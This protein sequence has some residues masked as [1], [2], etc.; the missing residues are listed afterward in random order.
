MTKTLLRAGALSCALLA[1]TALTAPASAQEGPLPRFNQVDANGVDLFTGDFFFSMVEGT[2]GSGDGALSLVRNWAG[3][4]GWTD[5]WSGTLYSTTIGG[6]V[7]VFVQFG[8][9]EDDFTLSGG[10]YTSTKADGASLASAGAGILRYVARD[11]TSIDYAL[12]APSGSSE[13][14][15]CAYTSCGIPLNMRRP[16]GMTYTMNWEIGDVCTQF[17]EGSCNH[18]LGFYRLAGVSSSAN[19]GFTID[20]AS[21][22]VGEDVAP[23]SNWFRRTQVQFTNLD[24]APASLPT[25]T[26]NQVSSTVLDVTDSGGQTWRLTNGSSGRLTGIRRPGAGSDTTAVSYSGASVSAV[27]NEGVATAY[28]RFTSGSGGSMT[29]TDAI[30]GETIAAFSLTTERI[31]SVFDASAHTTGYTYDSS[32]RLTRITQSEGNY[33]QYTYDARGNVTETLVKPKSGSGLPDLV[34]SA[35]YSSTC[36]NPVV[37]NLP[38]SST[39]AR[40][41][42]T[43]YTY[44]STHGGL[45]T[46]TAPAPGGSGDRPQTRYSYSAV[47]AVTG[48]PVTLPTGVS[49]CASGSAAG[50]P[51]CIGTAAESRTVIAYDSDNLRTTSVTQRNGDNSVSATSAFTYDAIGNTLTID[52]PLSGSA[53]TIRFRYDLARRTIGA[54]GPDPD[55]GG[56]LKHR[57]VRTTY[58]NGLPTS[59]EQGNVNSQSDGD[60]AAFAPA[61]RV[62]QIYDA[63][64]RPVAQR[65]ISGSTTYAL[66]QTSY[67]ALGRTRCVAQRMNPATFASP[68]TNACETGTEGSF[69]PDR[70]S[71]IGYD[72]I[73]RVTL[74]E[75]GVGTAAA[76]NERA[77]TY[78]AN[79]QVATV[80]DANGNRTTYVYDGHDR[81]S[82]KRMPDPSTPDTSS[83]SDFEDLT[84]ETVAG[85]TRAT[86]LVVSRRLRDTRAI[87]YSYDALGRLT[88]KNLPGAEL[89][90]TY[91]YDLLG[92]LTSAATSAQTLGFTY[93]ALGRRLSETGPVRTVSSGWDAAGRRQYVVADGHYAIRFAWL[94]TGEMS[95]LQNGNFDPVVTFAYDDLGRRTATAAFDGTSSSRSYDAVGRLTG[96]ALDLPSSGN[97]VTFGYSHNPAGEIASNTRSN[98]A[99]SFTL[100]NANIVGT[101]NGLN[102]LTSV[103]GASLVY[104]DNGNV[105]AI[106]AAGYGYDSE[107]RLVSAPGGTTL[108]Y[109]PLG[110]LYQVSDGT[111][112]RL[113]LYDG[114][115]LFGEY[116]ANGTPLMFYEN[117]PNVDEPVMWFNY[118]TF[119]F[120]TFHGDERGSVAA[121][122]APGG[123][124]INRYD[125]YGNPQGGAITGRFGYTGQIWLPQAGL[126][127]YRARAYNPALGRFMQTDPIGYGGGMN[128]YAYVGNNPVNLTDPAGTL[129]P[130]MTGTRIPNKQDWGPFC[131]SCSGFSTAGFAGTGQSGS[132]DTYKVGLVDSVTKAPVGYPWIE[133]RGT[134]FLSPLF[135]STSPVEPTRCNWSPL[136]CELILDENVRPMIIRALTEACPMCPTG[137]KRETGFWI[138]RFGSSYLVPHDM[139]YGEGMT[140][141]NVMRLRPDTASIFFH[142]HPFTAAEGGFMGFGPDDNML[143]NANRSYSF[144]AFGYMD[145]NNRIGHR[146]WVGR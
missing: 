99:Y 87:G 91:G 20:Y 139:I 100:A 45:L 1:S 57:A 8:T 21:D 19:Y 130:I 37:C 73:S 114:D 34:T 111:T 112:T 58:T 49:S 135:A 143:I 144:V 40:G 24:G 80:T 83:I 30:G 26:Y 137:Q 107:N 56:S 52:G 118:T 65:L 132:I 42:V 54:V 66:S 17:S 3:A 128:L 74:V 59:V 79:G 142:I 101:P 127:H 75:A 115:H 136:Y 76:A 4:A 122:V 134:G 131:G 27:T 53:D 82:R 22:D 133:I 84:Y 146:E 71:R 77:T 119:E 138:S 10:V 105:S 6:V 47:T 81:L 145:R 15:S 46:V 69:G 110:R 89:D 141:P 14:L 61:Q 35:S 106:G 60:W 96:L 62:E 13:A 43:D 7:H 94:A 108:T 103:G 113:F 123:T 64:A 126:Y 29:V 92:R 63:N 25:V 121:V 109:D 116:A 117:G 78:T 32:G 36:A 72:G 129:P 50:S 16:N 2:I 104:D 38:N 48:Q 18:I 102:Q 23:P 97:D 44:D 140:I 90:V 51:S 39:D 88:G 9:Y 67:D 86:P 98:D 12:E 41:N 55:G 120:G 33:V 68:H 5:N 85:G 70:I 125:D 95:A 31:T 93:D 124:T 28:S 11:G